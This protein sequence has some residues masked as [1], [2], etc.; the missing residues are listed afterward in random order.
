MSQ[1]NAGA[2]CEAGEHYVVH[3][4]KLTIYSFP[5]ARVCMAVHVDPPGRVCIIVTVPVGII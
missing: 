2:V 1:L 5:D 3:L 4:C